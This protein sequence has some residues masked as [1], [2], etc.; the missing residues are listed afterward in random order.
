[1]LLAMHKTEYRAIFI[2]YSST[3][4]V[5]IPIVVLVVRACCGHYTTALHAPVTRTMRF[6]GYIS[7]YLTGLC[8]QYSVVS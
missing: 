6:H 2:G 7:G 5:S 8:I 4:D 3:S 1:M